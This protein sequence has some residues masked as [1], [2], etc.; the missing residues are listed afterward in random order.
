MP[1][2]SPVSGAMP[3]RMLWAIPALLA[4]GLA[5]AA[6]GSGSTPEGVIN[7]TLKSLT[8]ELEGR[9]DELRGNQKDLYGLVDRVLLPQFDTHYAAQI[10]LGKHWR[11]ANEAQRKRFIDAF[12]NFLLR[13]YAK[14]ILRF[15]AN[16]FKVQ[17]MREPPKDGRAVVETIVKLDD[18]S[19]SP[20]NYSLHSTEN[21]WKVYDVRIEG[22]SYVQNY[23][24]Q[25]NEEIA[26]K[27]VDAVI[28]RLEKETADIDAG[29]QQPKVDLPPAKAA[30]KP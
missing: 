28:S 1:R 19:T 24:S 4:W 8:K 17:P 23:R 7:D 27:G 20:V 29:R 12:Y 30:G 26:A 16:N 25:F 11:E 2:S 9:R 5:A 3:R 21:G 13:S 18:G 6:P 14:A 15:D 22:V 10:V